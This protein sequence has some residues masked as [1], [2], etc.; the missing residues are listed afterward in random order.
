M[1]AQ[2]TGVILKVNGILHELSESFC[3]GINDTRL[4]CLLPIIIYGRKQGFSDE[5]FSVSNNLVIRESDLARDLLVSVQPNFF[6]N[7]LSLVG[8]HF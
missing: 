5:F 3:L 2:S 1:P 4:H 8:Q 7:S 6:E